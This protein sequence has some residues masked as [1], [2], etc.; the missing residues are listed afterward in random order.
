VSKA[1]GSPAPRARARRLSPKDRETLI[2]AG[3]VRYF[4][5]FGF[6][7]DTR[8]LAQHLGVGQP[9]LFK[10][11]PTKEA[12]IER[13]YQEVFVGRW[14][15]YWE[16]IIHNREK[17]LGDRLSDLYKAYARAVLD[18]QWIRLFMFAGLKDS[19]V[20]TRWLRFISE[21]MVKPVCAEVRHSLGLP[22]FSAVP[23]TD[24][25]QELVLGISSRIVSFGLRKFI[26]GTPVPDN[27]DPFIDAEV[28]I[29]VEGSKGIISDIVR[30]QA[31]RK[32]NGR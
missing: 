22:D 30:S 1:S 5:E 8:S 9:L 11:F 19:G 18:Y 31:V 4:A 29:F 24:M 17:P 12:L 27:V 10:Y 15:P 20:N 7:G 23:V 16:T 6:S 26:Y 32:R 21:H 13:V 3:A 28:Q 25:E 2:V 14:N